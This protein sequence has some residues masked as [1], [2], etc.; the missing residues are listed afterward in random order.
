MSCSNSR[1]EH[2][3]SAASSSTWISLSRKEN[4]ITWVSRDGSSVPWQ[5]DRAVPAATF[6]V[7]CSWLPWVVC[8]QKSFLAT[9]T[10][11]DRYSILCF[12][13]FFIPFPKMST[14]VSSWSGQM[15]QYQ[16]LPWLGSGPGLSVRGRDG[17][18]RSNIHKRSPLPP[19]PLQG[20][21][22]DLAAQG[23]P[24]GQVG[25]CLPNRD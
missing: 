16:N 2:T 6:T 7:T 3:P 15:K 5:Q 4:C 24:E 1:K 12:H 13:S 20:D 8:H 14:Q 25:R 11:T 18:T 22:I 10:G 17:V 21:G 23:S 19:F 9:D